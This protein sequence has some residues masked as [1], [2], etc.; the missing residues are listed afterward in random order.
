MVIKNWEIL[1]ADEEKQRE[2][3][4]EYG[5]S[6]FCKKSRKNSLRKRACVIT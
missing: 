6:S 5:I 2:I 4:K 1:K 3:V